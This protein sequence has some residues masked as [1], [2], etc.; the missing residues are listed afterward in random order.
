MQY[1]HATTPKTGL[2]VM[3]GLVDTVYEKGIKITGQ[4]LKDLNCIKDKQIP[5][6]NYSITPHA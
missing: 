3:A 4:K 6:W 5:N 1:L 2:N